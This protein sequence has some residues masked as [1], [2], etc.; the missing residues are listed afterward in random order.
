MTKAE[1]LQGIE[2]GLLIEARN[3]LL[4]LRFTEL[5]AYVTAAH[6]NVRVRLADLDAHK[7]NP[8]QHGTWDWA[9]FEYARGERVGLP[10]GRY[11]LPIATIPWEECKFTGGDFVSLK[12]MAL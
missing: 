10:D 5:E 4:R 7:H 2:A 1:L 3:G 12:W 6:A 11:W 8:Y 9:G